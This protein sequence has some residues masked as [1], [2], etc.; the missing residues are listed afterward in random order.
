MV[1]RLRV[2]QALNHLAEFIRHGHAVSRTLALQI[3]QGHHPAGSHPP[4]S[5]GARRVRHVQFDPDSAQRAMALTLM[6]ARTDRLA[7]TPASP[8]S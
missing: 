6:P 1:H 8:G 3:G 5:Q 4:R 7:Q 2:P